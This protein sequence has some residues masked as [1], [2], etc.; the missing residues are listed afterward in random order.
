MNPESKY[1]PNYIGNVIRILS[2][3]TLIVN[4]GKDILN[5]GDKIVV[6]AVGEPLI[7]IDGTVLTN[8]EHS[9]DTLS[10]IQTEDYY[11]VCR[12]EGTVVRKQL[13][14][15]LSPLLESEV[16]EQI[17][18]KVNEKDIQEL[19]PYDEYIRIGDPIKLA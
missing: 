11:S 13:S 4:A 15:A 5:V 14:F 2:D 19:A 18:L 12:K 8:F 1:G 6:Y 17:P 9:K 3:S 10:V 7:N 16:I